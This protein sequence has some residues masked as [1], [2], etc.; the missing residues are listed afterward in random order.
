MIWRC[1]GEFLNFYCSLIVYFKELLRKEK[2]KCAKLESKLRNSE[3]ERLGL[4]KVN[5]GY[6]AKSYAKHAGEEIINSEE[7]RFK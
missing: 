6:R 7:I 4:V 3:K 2:S 5:S 1:I